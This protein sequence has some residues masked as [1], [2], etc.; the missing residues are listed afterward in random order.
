MDVPRM[1]AS[2]RPSGRRCTVLYDDAE[3]A[4]DLRVV[5][6]TGTQDGTVVWFF[7]VK[8]VHL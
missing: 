6:S 5:G 2:Q 4:H 3:L 7:P 1:K 8:I